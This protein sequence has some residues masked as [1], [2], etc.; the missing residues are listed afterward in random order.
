MEKNK[1]KKWPEVISKV[2]E[3]SHKRCVVDLYVGGQ[4][5]AALTI[6]A[7]EN[8]PAAAVENFWLEVNWIEGV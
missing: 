4:P 5:A 3:R 8:Q 1:R 2:R 7:V 6:F